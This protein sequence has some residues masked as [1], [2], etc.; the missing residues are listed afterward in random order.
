MDDNILDEINQIKKDIVKSLTKKSIAS[1]KEENDTVLMNSV[2]LGWLQDVENT[3]EFYTKYCAFEQ[4]CQLEEVLSL[5]NLI[6]AIYNDS[7]N[8][9]NV[10]NIMNS[11][12]L[13]NEIIEK[14][15]YKLLSKKCGYELPD[16]FSKAE[17]YDDST[18]YDKVNFF[19]KFKENLDSIKDNVMG[20]GGKEYGK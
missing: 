3:K 18:L 17:N 10:N 1:T 7:V 4:L 12:K 20:L 5:F 16:S 11:I 15:E 19:W 6:D 2:L 13:Y 14:D 9:K 8:S